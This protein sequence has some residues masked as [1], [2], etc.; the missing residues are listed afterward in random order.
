MGKSKG[1]IKGNN[2]VHQDATNQDSLNLEPT[3]I[4]VGTMDGGSV[5]YYQPMLADGCINKGQNERNKQSH[6]A[7]DSLLSTQGSRTEERGNIVLIYKTSPSFRRLITTAGTLGQLNTECEVLITHA[8]ECCG[9]NSIHIFENIIAEQL[10]PAKEQNKETVDMR[11]Y[12]SIYIDEVGEV[13]LEQRDIKLRQDM[14]AD[15]SIGSELIL[16]SWRDSYLVTGDTVLEGES[17][18]VY[19]QGHIKWGRMK[20][21]AEGVRGKRTY[22]CRLPAAVNIKECFTDVPVTPDTWGSR[23]EAMA[24]EDAI[25]AETIAAEPIVEQTSVGGLIDSRKSTA[26]ETAADQITTTTTKTATVEEVVDREAIIMASKFTTGAATA[27]EAL[28]REAANED[29]VAEETIAGEVGKKKKKRRPKK[30]KKPKDES[31]DTGSDGEMEAEVGM[32]AEMSGKYRPESQS[33]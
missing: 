10:T 6:V 27:Q 19:T 5:G 15:G 23:D 24:D 14:F 7:V 30:S 1:R 22:T 12:D 26:Q 20:V 25:V 33:R 4:S 9:E 21:P 32:S 31:E 3:F 28:A 13:I 8:I 11:V 2:E 17:I 18:I 29:A 16:H